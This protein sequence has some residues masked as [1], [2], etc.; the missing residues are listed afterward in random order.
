[1]SNP[2]GARLQMVFEERDEWGTADDLQ[3]SLD[4]AGLSIILRHELALLRHERAEYKEMLASCHETRKDA[5]MKVRLFAKTVHQQAV[6]DAMAELDH[7]EV[8]S[9]TTV[10]RP[11]C[12]AELARREAEKP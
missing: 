5:L 1:M 7:E 6:L 10:S 9:L 3:R 12:N 11:L 2:N 8:L 4:D